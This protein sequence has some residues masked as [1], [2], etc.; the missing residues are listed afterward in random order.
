[1]KLA[2]KLHNACTSII[3][4][5][6][7][8]ILMSGTTTPIFAATPPE[9]DPAGQV[10][11]SWQEFKELLKLDTDEIK[12]SWEEFKRLLAQTGK[13]V[14]VE[15]NIQNGMVILQR[16]QFKKLLEQMQ[17]PAA[18]ALKPPVDY[19]ITKAEYIATMN[20]T[21]T[22]FKA[23]FSVEIF[24]NGRDF[25]V[26][27]RLLPKEVALRDIKMDNAQ[28]LI[29]VENGWYVLTT[30]KNGQHT[31]DVE[32]SVK[33]SL[34]QKPAALSLTIPQTAITLFKVDVP[35]KDVIV[36]IPH[37]QHTTITHA[38]G[39]TAVEAQLSTT[40]S[41]QV[42]LKQ[43]VVK[44]RG[45]GP[46]KIYAETMNLLSIE[47]GALRVTAHFKIDILQYTV[48]D[49]KLKVPEGYS[50][51]YVNDKTGQEIHG[52]HS[53]MDN[54]NELLTIP[55]RGDIEGS[56][57]F[58]VVAEKLLPNGE[59]EVAFTGF[60]VVGALRHTG[61]IGIEKRSNAEAQISHA[62]DLD[63]VDVLELPTSLISMS[64]RPLIFGLKYVRHPFDLAVKITKHEELPVIH[65]VIDNANG[66]SVFLK[67]GKVITRVVYTVQN[68][69][70]QFL[71]LALPEGAEI[72]SLYVDGVRET[73]ARDEDGTFMIPLARSKIQNGI[74]T[75]FNVE[76]L[77]YTEAHKFGFIGSERLQF[78][79]TD[80][81][82][83]KL[84]WSCYFPLDYQF[85]YFS[86]NVEKELI[87][88]GVNPLL[89][90]NR[91]FTYDDLTTYNQ[92]LENWDVP[93]GGV[94][95]RIEET[96]RAL[97]SDFTSGSVSEK[98][99]LLDQLREEINFTQN[100]QREQE[101][102][103]LLTIEIP[104]SGQLYR[105]AKT[106]IKDEALYVEAHYM[107][108]WFVTAIKLLV[109]IGLLSALILARAYIRR[110]FVFIAQ[111]ITKH[112][113]VF[114][115]L[116]TPN[117]VRV[118]L[119]VAA[120]VSWFLTKI[121]FVIFVILVILTWIRP[122]WIFRRREETSKQ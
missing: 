101:H 25:Y 82:I 73:P 103:A 116:K 55:F 51:L 115:W 2:A 78:P 113:D 110:V 93:A 107:R 117:G 112:K 86:G 119:I 49:L 67:D 31:I 20:Q 76:V 58:A 111:W 89:G 5:A 97:S 75:Q 13:E 91:V 95:K 10:R 109:I 90:K 19:L 21:S 62:G 61:F 18:E 87:A 27:I 33:S 41:L 71:E 104:T 99:M 121:L 46:A 108:A 44:E 56:V 63:K 17:V 38:A 24:E 60:E 8:G 40:N 3:A 45:K 102:G 120:C 48:R 88:S 14:K 53:Q 7:I 64:Q 39:H 59:N 80:V 83:S 9:E 118:L 66:V 47:D 72:W 54:G 32:F 30:D 35:I 43:V 84:L 36:E 34:E 23:K 105:F 77:Y 106:I 57:E 122:E 52:W 70:K 29:M 16:E 100:I 6:I 22:T 12:L 85:T 94:D 92:A 15:Y 96:R 68:T 81:V 37:E 50:V 1:M 28:A 65:T 4:V 42:K 79:R 98:D 74:I 11:M 114:A 26:K 69:E